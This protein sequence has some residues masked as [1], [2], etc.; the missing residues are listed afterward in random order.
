MIFTFAAAT[1][2]SCTCSTMMHFCNYSES[3]DTESV[4]MIKM[5]DTFYTSADDNRKFY[6]VEVVRHL[7]GPDLGLDSI[8]LI[9]QNTTFDY[10]LEHF[11]D[12]MI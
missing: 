9:F 4:F 5:V 3:D 10:D 6:D 1:G 8:T 7:F 12:T 2:Y 11:A